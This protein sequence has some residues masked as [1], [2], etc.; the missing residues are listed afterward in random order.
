[1]LQGLG[2][3][4]LSSGQTTVVA[5]WEGVRG[6]SPQVG[7]LRWEQQDAPPLSEEEEVRT[8]V[9]RQFVKEVGAWEFGGGS[10]GKGSQED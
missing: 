1:M 4:M 5:A 6:S 2:L 8:A 7:A 3:A 9:C 10:G